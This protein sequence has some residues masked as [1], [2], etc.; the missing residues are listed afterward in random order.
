MAHQTLVTAKWLISKKSELQVKFHEFKWGTNYGIPLFD[1]E[2]SIIGGLHSGRGSSTDQNLA[3]EKAAAEALERFVCFENG[4]STEGVAAHSIAEFAGHNA[5]REAI[6][7]YL[8]RWHLNTKTPFISDIALSKTQKISQAVVARGGT[9]SWMKLRP[10]WAYESSLCLIEK[11]DRKFLG[12]GLGGNADE[13]QLHAAI[14]ALRNFAAYCE[15]KEQFLE[16]VETNPDL[17]CC[18]SSFFESHKNV[19]E[20]PS[21]VSPSTTVPTNFPIHRE[22]LASRTITDIPLTFVRATIPGGKL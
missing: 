15:N 7:R 4:I 18:S 13:T 21:I 11:D 14:E 2:I 12:I 9:I 17:W 19:F 20:K 10:A 6:E 8:F 3:F 22:T 16:A 5:G 1:F